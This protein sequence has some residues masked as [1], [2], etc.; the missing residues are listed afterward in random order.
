M[1]PVLLDTGVIVALLDRSERHHKSCEAALGAIAGPLV[2]CEAVIAESCY[3]LRFLPGVRQAILENVVAGTFQIP[4][5]LSRCAS[6]IQRLLRKYQDRDVDF[7][8]ACLIHLA[9]EFHTGDIL[10]LDHD[11][12]IYRWSGNKP[13]HLLIPVS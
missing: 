13:F 6:Q 11:F 2:T 8:D 5:Q 1:K 9:T 4:F 10:T 7:A 12:E 3:L